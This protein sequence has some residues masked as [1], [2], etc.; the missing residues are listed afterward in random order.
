MNFVATPLPGV[1][2]VEPEPIS[3]ERGFFA[4]TFCSK[5][6][7]AQGLDPNLVQCNISFNKQKGTLRGM[8]YQV[9]PHGEAKLVRVTQGSVYDVAL[10]MRPDSPTYCRWFALELS[11]QNHR[12]LY[13]PVGCAHGFQS[14]EDASE[15][16]Y[17]MSACYQPEAARGVRWDDPAFA[18]AWPLPDPIMSENDRGFSKFVA[19]AL[20]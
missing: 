4:R 8:H 7:T 17:Q 12:A 11:A 2:V 10:D 9:M 6:F 5:E 19:N 3:D 18:I 20:A 1:F 16:F 15:V 13:V 14:L